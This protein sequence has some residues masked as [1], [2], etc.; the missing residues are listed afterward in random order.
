VRR[1]VILPLCVSSVYV[2]H[3]AVTELDIQEEWEQADVSD[4][5]RDEVAC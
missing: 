3:Q 4:W 2:R 1:V 5:T